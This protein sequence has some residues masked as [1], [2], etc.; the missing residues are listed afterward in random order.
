MSGQNGIS[1]IKNGIW[2]NG[3]RLYAFLWGVHGYHFH[4]DIPQVLCD[5]IDV[6]IM[7][8]M[9]SMQQLVQHI[10]KVSM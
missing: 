2:R 10:E 4:W 7:K 9:R 8:D 3:R 1:G 6:M 5:D